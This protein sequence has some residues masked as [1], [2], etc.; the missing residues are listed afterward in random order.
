MWWAVVLLALVACGPG[1]WS[2]DRL[3]GLEG[4]RHR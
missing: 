3:L 1:A 4:R 2:L